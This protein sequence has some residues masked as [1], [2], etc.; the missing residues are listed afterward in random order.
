[1]KLGIH[2]LALSI[3]DR[4]LLAG[5]DAMLEPGRIVAILGPA[6]SGKGALLRA[7]A[8]RHDIDAGQVRL[9]GK[10]IGRYARAERAKAIL[11]V[12]ARPGLFA[13]APDLASAVAARPNWLLVEDPLSALDPAAQLDRIAQFRA[14]AGQGT[15]M[16]LT[17]ADPVLAARAA[18]DVLLLGRGRML[19]FGPARAALAH[20]NLREAFGIEV[21]VIGDE[22]GRLLPVPI[23]RADG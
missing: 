14:A 18:D 22:G 8:G 10:L 19:A 4:R 3:G 2:N 9:G 7:L 5:V 21:M 23:G 12:G 15:G 1:M 20:Q 11:L 6:G 16:V 17:L 13:R